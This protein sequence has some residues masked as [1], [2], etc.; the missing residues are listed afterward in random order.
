[1]G[2]R[3]AAA[4]GGARGLQG[5]KQVQSARARVAVA[6]N[7]Y[8]GVLRRRVA[9]KMATPASQV[10]LLFSG[11]MPEML[12]EHRCTSF[13]HP[14]TLHAACTRLGRAAATKVPALH[15]GTAAWTALP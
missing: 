6:A 9:S 7:N 13:L 2:V 12:H 4:D 14:P 1:M 10:R 8:V 11:A 5:G 15:D 3:A